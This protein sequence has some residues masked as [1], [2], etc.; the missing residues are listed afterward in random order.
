MEHL[1]LNHL[2]VDLG[3]RI[4]LSQEFNNL[5]SVI[6]DHCN[7]LG[8]NPVINLHLE[9][10]AR[11]GSVLFPSDGVLKLLHSFQNICGILLK[12]L[13]DVDSLHLLQYKIDVDELVGHLLEGPAGILS[14]LIILDLIF[15]MT[16]KKHPL[17]T[18][19]TG[20]GKD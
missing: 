4:L 18:G 1:D 11:V 19:K 13:V 14:A 3:K 20:R 6:V 15:V 2:R 9:H 8:G 5:L 17:A 7:P 12:L 10:R 16:D